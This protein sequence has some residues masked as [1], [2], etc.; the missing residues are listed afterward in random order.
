MIE[1][2]KTGLWGYAENMGIELSKDDCHKAVKIFRKAYSEIVEA[3]YAYEDAIAHTIRT[4][5]AP[6]SGRSASR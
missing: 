6:E 4:G 3:W 5:R 2:K 1:G